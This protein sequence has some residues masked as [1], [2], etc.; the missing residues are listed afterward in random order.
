MDAVSMLVSKKLVALAPAHIQI[1]IIW[2][3]EKRTMEA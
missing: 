2:A 3:E 1:S